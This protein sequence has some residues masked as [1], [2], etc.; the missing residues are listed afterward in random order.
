ML[1]AR[2]GRGYD[3]A[4]DSIPCSAGLQATEETVDAFGTTRQDHRVPEC[5][6]KEVCLGMWRILH[7]PF[8]APMQGLRFVEEQVYGS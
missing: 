3:G 4:I 2:L 8:D 1:G 5:R 7:W 6:D